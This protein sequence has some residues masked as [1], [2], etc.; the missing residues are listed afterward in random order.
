MKA[1]LPLYSD[2]QNTLKQWQAILGQSIGDFEDRITALEEKIRWY[3]ITGSG[4]I[5]YLNATAGTW[6]DVTGM[7]KEV[8]FTGKGLVV[9]FSQAS[10]SN[11]NVAANMQTR[12]IRGSTVLGNICQVESSEASTLA[13]VQNATNFALEEVEAGTYTYKL[14]A[15]LG[16]GSAGDGKLDLRQ[17]MIFAL[18]ID[19]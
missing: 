10:I 19:G 12:L 18:N 15:A 6:N 1:G 17:M 5:T 16:G 14:Q 11:T 8:V 13:R 3:F 9:L 7:S 4:V 2:L